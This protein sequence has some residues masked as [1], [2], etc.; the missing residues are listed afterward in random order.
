MKDFILGDCME[1]MKQYPDN[2]FDLAIADPMYDLPTNY[3]VPGSE[4]TKDG[5]KRKHRNAAK[6]LS[7][8]QI[9]GIEWFK[10][11]KRV[12]V[13]QIIWGINYFPFAGEIC[14]RL[15][16]DKKNDSSSFSNAEIAACSVIKGV[17]IFRYTWNGFMQE[18]MKNKEQRIHPFQKPIQLYKWILNKYANSTDRILSTHVGSG[19]D[20]IAF[21]D[22]G[23]EYVG[24]E[25][26]SEYFYAA[27]KRLEQHKAQLKLF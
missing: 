23:C 4:K 5:V 12:S 2:H 13:N 9:V 24:Y 15:I 7:K 25:I 22:F 16:W 6:K 21:E 18:D 19:S 17:R 1:G 26:D 10:E 11:L 14:G 20:L 8:Q 3:L 27:Q